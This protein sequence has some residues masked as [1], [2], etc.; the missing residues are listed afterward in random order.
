MREEEGERLRLAYIP[1]SSQSQN[2][3][4][5]RCPQYITQQSRLKTEGSPPSNS[6]TC[7][8]KAQLALPLAIAACALCC[9]SPNSSNLALRIMQL[10]I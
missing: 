6:S 10:E 8:S 4:I 7:A 1:S 5:C 9:K 2:A 3:V